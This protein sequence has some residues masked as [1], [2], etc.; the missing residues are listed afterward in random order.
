MGRVVD[1]M[2]L[3]SRNKDKPKKESEHDVVNSEEIIKAIQRAIDDGCLISASSPE[4]SPSEEGKIIGIESG[5]QDRLLIRFY[6]LTSFESGSTFQVSFE[7]SDWRYSFTTTVDKQQDDH[8][9]LCS[10]PNILRDNERRAAPRVRLRKNEMVPIAAIAS[11]FQGAAASGPVTELSMTGF[12][13]RP[14]RIVDIGSQQVLSVTSIYFTAGKA[15]A[16][17]RVKL[18]GA[19]RESEFSAISRRSW[20]FNP[21]LY[22]A[23]EFDRIESSDLDHVERILEGRFVRR[24]LTGPMFPDEQYE[25][26]QVREPPR[27]QDDSPIELRP[28]KPE[29]LSEERPSPSL[30]KNSKTM[31]APTEKP[32]I[33]PAAPPPPVAVAVEKG[34][35]PEVF[36]EPTPPGILIVG[37]TSLSR[38]QLR[39]ILHGQGFQNVYD[40]EG[41]DEAIQCFLEYNCN[42]VLLGLDL[43]DM[44]AMQFVQMLREQKTALKTPIIIFGRSLDPAAIVKLKAGGINDIV[45]KPIDAGILANKIRKYLE[46]K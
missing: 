17:A 35:N 44:P 9:V 32:E 41:G 46:M 16:V 36:K 14:Q 24:S 21:N 6:Q 11:L 38:S 12:C 39:T 10:M 26:D 7:S 5:K 27:V 43:S 18:P 33:E 23:M 22:V 15:F 28:Q 1:I 37:D 2:G 8:W 19:A 4:E 20:G 31:T 30:I 45:M 25:R 3:F 29:P 42:L 34:P 40:A 13:F